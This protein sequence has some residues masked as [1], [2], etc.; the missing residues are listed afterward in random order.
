[1]QQEKDLL[2]IVE[3]EWD[4]RVKRVRGSGNRRRANGNKK[5]KTGSYVS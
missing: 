5:H 4:W 2:K 1:M 3:D